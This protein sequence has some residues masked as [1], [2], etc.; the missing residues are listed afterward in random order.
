M[1]RYEANFYII[2]AGAKGKFFGGF[3]ITAFGG[4][5]GGKS[6]RV[7]FNV[8]ILVMDSHIFANLQVLFVHSS[9]TKTWFYICR[10]S[11]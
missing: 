1:M 6:M 3:D 7:A 8:I 9:S 11:Y 2:R 5:Q 10:D 4:F